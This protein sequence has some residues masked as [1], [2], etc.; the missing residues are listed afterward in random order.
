MKGFQ[1][2][3]FVIA[4]FVFITTI[5]FVTLIIINNIPLFY[6][7]A[8]TESLKSKSYQHSQILLLDAGYPSNWNTLPLT[9][10]SRIGLSSGPEYFIDKN[11]INKLAEFCSTPNNYETVKIKL[12]IAAERD[13]IIESSYPDGT[14]VGAS[15]Q[16]CKPPITTQI[17]QQ[18]QTTRFGVL[19][20]PDR[21][22]VSIRFIIIN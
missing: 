16:I 20:T 12:G 21:E 5:S 8:Q 13:I 15:L 6:N 9:S 3:E 18:F 2:I 17:R 22:I 14:P 1:E 11:K 4:I 7:I 19:D 10:I